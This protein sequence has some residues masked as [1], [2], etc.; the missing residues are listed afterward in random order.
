MIFC[1]GDSDVRLRASVDYR[2]EGTEHQVV[3]PD[4]QATLK[5]LKDLNAE[6]IRDMHL[7]VEEIAVLILKG[8]MGC[9]N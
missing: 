2:R 8:G 1:L 5:E 4:F 3:T 7:S 6:N 9:G